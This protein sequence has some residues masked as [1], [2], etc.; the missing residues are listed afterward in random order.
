MTKKIL[1]PA[2]LLVF[3]IALAGCGT[4]SQSVS[5]YENSGNW[6]YLETAET[7]AAD[8]FFICPTV[9]GG[10]DD[11]YNMS[12]EDTAS[13][14][15][16]A[17]ATNMEKGIYDEDA[18]LFAPYYRQAGLNVY[19]LPPEEREAYLSLAYEDI[20]EAFT[21]YLEH[22]NQGRPIVLAGFS[23]GADM[24]IRLL[25]DCFAREEVNDLLV[26]CYAIGWR[27]T[28]EELEKYPHLRFATGETDTGVI[29]S[30]NSEAE[31]VTDFLMIPAGTRTLA[32]NPLNWK[33]D[34]TPASREENAGACFT[35]YSGSIVTE[36]PHL[37]GAYIDPQRGALKVP[38]VSPQEY[39]PVLSIFSDGIY[40]LY[41]YQFFY[42]NLQENVGVRIDA[43]LSR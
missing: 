5:L 37:T 11:S 1:F 35:D 34:S 41:D 15:A 27:I 14:E 26:A 20:K 4:E 18:R 12:L 36:I 6:V 31:S 2:A 23:Q 13:K 39:P 33:T 43:Y 7:A 3:L 24:S 28:E 21:Y 17:G 10:T 29:I 25:K 9:Y 19:E 16:F 42:R 32:I 8:V 30:F 22:Y 38:D 40:H